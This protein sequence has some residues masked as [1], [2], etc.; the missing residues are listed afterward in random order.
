MLLFRSL[1]TGLLGACVLLLVSLLA[2]S[3]VP[4]RPPAPAPTALHPIEGVPTIIDVSPAIRAADLPSLVPL[5]NGEHVLAIGDRGVLSDFSAGAEIARSGLT[6][7]Q[8][9]DLTVG[10]G[11]TTRRVLVLMH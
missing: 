9:L 1:T 2:R 6:S 8:Y 4:A 5:S 11:V 3:P 7:G 10:N